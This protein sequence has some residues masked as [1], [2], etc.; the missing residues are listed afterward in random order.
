[1]KRNYEDKH[2]KKMKKGCETVSGGVPQ[3]AALD[4]HQQD[5]EF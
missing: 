1:M 3:R 4:H 2:R 5:I